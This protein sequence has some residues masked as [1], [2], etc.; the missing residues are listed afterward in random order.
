MT[1]AKLIKDPAGTLSENRWDILSVFALC[2]VSFCLILPIWLKGIPTG[3]DLPQHFQFA[4]T[5]H[6]A[7]LAG[8]YYPSWMP[9]EN[10]GYGGV[11]MRFYPPIGYYTL[12]LVRIAVG[13]W[14]DAA[15]IVFTFWLALSGL[16][17]YLWA[18]ERFGY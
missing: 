4:I 16:G 2:V 18:R 3:N 15:C 12:A 10:K 1:L 5:I 6:D 9:H 14:F 13:N 7:L 8:D 11:G 17:A